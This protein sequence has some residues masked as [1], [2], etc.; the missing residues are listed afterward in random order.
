MELKGQFEANAAREVTYSLAV[1]HWWDFISLPTRLEKG[2]LT[3]SWVAN[4]NGRIARS[5]FPNR[6]QPNQI[7]TRHPPLISSIKISEQ[8][9]QLSTLI[10]FVKR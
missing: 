1:S 4:L 5:P 6:C 10:D 2:N 9:V 3:L 7:L 8:N